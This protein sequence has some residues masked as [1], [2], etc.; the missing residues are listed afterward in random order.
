MR[1]RMY[2]LT[3]PE[4]RCSFSFVWERVSLCTCGWPGAH[5]ISRLAS[6]SERSTK[7]RDIH[8]RLQLCK[9]KL[10]CWQ[11]HVPPEVWVEISHLLRFCFFGVSC[12]LP[13]ITLLSVVTRPSCLC[14]FTWPSS[15]KDP[16]HI[17]L[18]HH[19]NLIKSLKVLLPHDVCAWVLKARVSERQ[20]PKNSLECQM[21]P[22]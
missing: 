9:F 4:S 12:I 18:D 21:A 7:I 16:G 5:Y 15:N 11:N 13:H 10:L 22:E 3:V 20:L 8:D 2:G 6:N 14:V 1:T 19:L 17:R